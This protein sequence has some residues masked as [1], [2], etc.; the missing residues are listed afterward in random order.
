METVVDRT[1]AGERIYGIT[2]I[3][4]LPFNTALP[5]R[6]GALDDAGVPGGRPAC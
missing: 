4:F 5:A 2:G 1:S 6:R 3:Q